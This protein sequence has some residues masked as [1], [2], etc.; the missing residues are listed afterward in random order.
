MLAGEPTYRRAHLPETTRRR[1]DGTIIDVLLTIS[2]WHA[3]GEVVGV[4]G[5]ALDLSKRKR[6]EQDLLKDRAKLEAALS[7]RMGPRSNA[8]GS[9]DALALSGRPS[10]S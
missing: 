1:K 3:D 2:P 5:T 6:I 10:K 4:T 7:S 9:R 8:A